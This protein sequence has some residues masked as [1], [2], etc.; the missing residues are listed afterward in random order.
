MGSRGEDRKEKIKCITIHHSRV[1]SCGVSSMASRNS[2]RLK[3]ND[4]I[5]LIPQKCSDCS[6]RDIR[7]QE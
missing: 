5:R 2:E 1:K 7:G 4:T 3:V 6:K